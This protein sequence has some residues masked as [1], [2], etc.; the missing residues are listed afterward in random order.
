MQ[1]LMELLGDNDVDDERDVDEYQLH[2]QQVNDKQI[3][4][5]IFT[6]YVAI[7]GAPD[8][9]EW[10]NCLGQKGLYITIEDASNGTLKSS[11]LLR[12]QIRRA[13]TKIREC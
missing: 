9:D 4:C 11:W 6:Q 2:Q 1:L 5:W 12:K 7:I 8:S 3:R 13:L 10:E